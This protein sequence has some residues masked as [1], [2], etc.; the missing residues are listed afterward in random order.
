V[1][2]TIDEFVIAKVK[3]MRQLREISQAALA[4][5]LNISR[6]FIGDVENPKKRSKYNLKMLNEIAKI[7]D[8]SIRDFLPERYL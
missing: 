8:C 4:D 3:E 2:N 7:L 5:Y 6:G 1:E